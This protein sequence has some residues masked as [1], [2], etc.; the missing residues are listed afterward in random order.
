M[1]ATA[2]Q[3]ICT[4]LADNL[5]AYKAPGQSEEMHKILGVLEVLD[6]EPRVPS[7]NQLAV[8]F[9]GLS[10]EDDTAY[11]TIVVFYFRN[12]IEEGAEE[13]ELKK[14]LDKIAPAIFDDP[15]VSNVAIGIEGYDEELGLIET[16]RDAEIQILNGAQV[17]VVYEVP[18]AFFRRE[19]GGEV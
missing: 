4:N 15:T 12:R 18:A 1:N 10:I 14:A 16:L 8:T 9:A 13:A 7:P 6:S 17:T 19:R 5:K 3:T 11:V 2:R